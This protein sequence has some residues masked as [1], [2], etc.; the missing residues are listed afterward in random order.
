MT[1][2]GFTNV[3]ETQKESMGMRS[4]AEIVQSYG[5]VQGTEEQTN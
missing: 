2:F 3:P 4:H 1:H 5:R